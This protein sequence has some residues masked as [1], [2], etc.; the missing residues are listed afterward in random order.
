[1]R[2]SY[3]EHAYKD[4]L[5]SGINLGGV[6]LLFYIIFSTEDPGWV[7][8]LMGTAA[9]A[10]VFYSIRTTHGKYKKADE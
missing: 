7:G 8:Y 4:G 3:Y 1:M 2:K 6:S 9:F 10:I 5:Y